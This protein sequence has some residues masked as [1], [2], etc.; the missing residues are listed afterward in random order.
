MSPLEIALILIGIVAFVVSFMV[1]EKAMTQ[2]QEEMSAKQIKKIYE[3]ESVL[4]KQIFEDK[5]QEEAVKAIQTVE[6]A[7]EKTSNE[8][9]MAVSEYSDSVLDEIG[10]AHKEVL[11]L[12]SMMC[13]K[14]QDVKKMLTSIKQYAK[15]TEQIKKDIAGIV[16]EDALNDMVRQPRMATQQPVIDESMEQPFTTDNQYG[17]KAELKTEVEENL[18]AEL[19]MLIKQEEVSGKKYDKEKK[20]SSSGM[21][22]KMSKNEEVIALAEKGL[23]EVEIAK[24]LGIG[25]GEVKL[26]LE[27]YKSQH[28]GKHNVM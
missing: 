17:E 6:R 7:L 16:V 15:E 23:A 28:S 5:A 1:P 14:E 20:P 9:I 27:L 10:K 3:K 2:K 25:R 21:T 11:F 13:D 18:M 8:K 4:A 19:E 26:V 22:K 12:H 24:Q